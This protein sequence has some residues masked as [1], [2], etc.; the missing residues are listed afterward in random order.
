[1]A[2]LEGSPNDSKMLWELTNQALGKQRPSL[3]S[4]LTLP[5]G[6]KTTGNVS[7]AETMMGYYIDKVLN[8]RVGIANAPPAPT[9]AW[10]ATKHPFSFSF[11]TGGKVA[12]TIKNLKNT[13]ALGIDGIP[14]SILKKGVTLLATPL[15]HLVN[16]SLAEGVVPVGFKS[17]KIYPVHKGNRKS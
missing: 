10:P 12:K 11:A 6:S 8:L 17:A 13:E 3:P 1:M 4:S 7:A 14:V 9:P 16:R 2:R 15:A 5:D